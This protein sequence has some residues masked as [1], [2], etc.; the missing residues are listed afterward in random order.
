MSL[1]NDTIQK[2]KLNPN[3]DNTVKD[4][5]PTMMTDSNRSYKATLD[6]LQEDDK[7]ALKPFKAVI[8]V[9]AEIDSE[10]DHRFIHISERLRNAVLANRDI[11]I[12]ANGEIVAKYTF[13]SW[14]L[15]ESLNVAMYDSATTVEYDSTLATNV[16]VLNLMFYVNT[17]S[18][19]TDWIIV[20]SARAG[21]IS[22]ITINGASILSGGVA[23]IAVEGNYDA[24]SNKIATMNALPVKDVKLDNTSVVD[25]NGI[26][27]FN[28]ITKAE[29]DEICQ[30]YGGQGVSP[31]RDIQIDGYTILNDG[32]ASIQT[33]T[34]YNA[35]S[36]KIATMADLP[37]VP[38]N[39]VT[40]D[41]TQTISGTKTF[42]SPITLYSASGDSPMWIFQ[43]GTLVD[44]YNDWGIVDSGGYLYFKQ[45]GTGATDWSDTRMIMT[46]SYV[47]IKGAIYENGTS[48]SSKYLAKST[49]AGLVKNDGTIDTNSYITS[50]DIPINSIETTGSGNA[51]TS[52]TLSSKKITFDKGTTFLTTHQ[53]IKTLKTDNTT[54]QTTSASEAIAGSGTINLHK[55]AKTGS[56]N[57]L[58]NTPTIPTVN[59]STITIKK[60]SSDT[61]DSFTTNASSGKT[62]NLGLATVATSG[63]YNDLSNKPTIPSITQSSITSALG[64][65]SIASNPGWGTTT[66]A[67]GYTIRWSSA[68]DGGGG[69]IFSEKNGQTFIQIDGEI[70]VSEGQKRLAHIDEVPT[71]KYKHHIIVQYLSN[72]AIS[73]TL[74]TTDSSAYTSIAQIESALN[75]NGFNSMT[76]YLPASGSYRST[77]QP[78]VGVRYY[79]S[80]NFGIAY[81][82]GSNYNNFYIE[83]IYMNVRQDY[84]TS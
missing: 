10:D 43:R 68:Q 78:V 77:T 16:E 60:N 45:R 55:V 49:T 37:S 51:I 30:G 61:G 71:K 50:S 15:I 17:G 40:T 39:Y 20:N 31:I 76:T 23:N 75:A 7:I 65:G 74:E 35:S 83:N 34:A 47:D 2:I 33:N 42:T 18:S 3:D 32:V 41:T 64:L 21:E 19:S 5:A 13:G 27:Q 84:V 56:Y 72:A 4:I 24:S 36:N 12:M 14:Q 54:A 52:A 22:N 29:I 53:S 11:E 80:S 28:E 26:A 82:T 67:N 48:L 70:Y 38:T 25:A 69:L 44:D 59:D 58:L 9:D 81:Y 1:P 66:A 62:I 57:D 46:Q 63:S 8:G 79:D 73:F 6:S